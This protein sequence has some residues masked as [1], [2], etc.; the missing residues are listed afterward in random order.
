LTVTLALHTY[1]EKE[2]E[3]AYDIDEYGVRFVKEDPDAP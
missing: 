2:E 1:E 3:I